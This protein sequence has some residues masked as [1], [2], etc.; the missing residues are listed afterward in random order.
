MS[1][2][3]SLEDLWHALHVAVRTPD[4]ALPVD[5]VLPDPEARLAT[6]MEIKS[7]RKDRLTIEME[8]L[9]QEQEVEVPVMTEEM[10]VEEPAPPVDEVTDLDEELRSRLSGNGFAELDDVSPE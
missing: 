6:F 3:H 5:A 10:G 7:R 1:T 4:K 2:R 8:S 9:P